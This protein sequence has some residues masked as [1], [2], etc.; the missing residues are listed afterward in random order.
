LTFKGIGCCGSRQCANHGDQKVHWKQR[1]KSNFAGN[2]EEREAERDCLE[3]AIEGEKEG[4]VQF[5]LSAED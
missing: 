1:K 3:S 2:I 5:K 4:K